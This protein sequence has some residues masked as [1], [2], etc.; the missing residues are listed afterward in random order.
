MASKSPKRIVP[1]VCA[2]LIVGTAVTLLFKT[3][4]REQADRELL[5]G[6]RSADLVAVRTALQAGANP[7]CRGLGAQIHD[8]G[9]GA[10]P[11]IR[12]LHSLMTDPTDRQP[13]MDPER[14]PSALDLAERSGNPEIVRLLLD[15][16]ADPNIRQRDGK[17]TLMVAA[18]RG[19]ADIVNVLL[20]HHADINAST[21][22]GWTAMTFALGGWR[23][24][25][26][27]L[28]LHRG[29]RFID[30]KGNPQTAMVALLNTQ[31]RANDSAVGL[32]TTMLETLL[33]AGVPANGRNSRGEPMVVMAAEQS[34]TSSIK[35]NLERLLAHGADVNAPAPDGATALMLATN[36]GSYGT[37]KLLLDHGA[38]VNRRTSSGSTALIMA[39][40][41][42]TPTARPTPVGVR[43]RSAPTVP[44][45]AIKIAQILLDHGAEVNAESKLGE[46]PLTSAIRAGSLSIVNLLL[47]HGAQVNTSH[48][49]ADLTVMD[50][51]PTPQNRTPLMRS[52]TPLMLAAIYS[53]PH[54]LEIARLLVRNGARVDAVDASGNTAGKLALLN[55][56]WKL[57]R[58][59]Q[60]NSNTTPKGRTR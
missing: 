50:E 59:L 12:L 1:L 13:S 25:V 53:N 23:F 48:F 18:A 56:N 57:A 34:G 49:R 51:I 22:D 5:E 11:L 16:G 46:T 31:Q 14:L 37:V 19:E 58:L 54:S 55:R 8:P 21:R 6:I 29:A 47:A 3:L 26:V 7:N 43:P 15:H 24:E 45:P 9:A 36:I 2:L 20:D 30:G 39:A 60:T 35:A 40:S 32:A 38:D 41:L 28:L 52:E 33:N 27:R 44:S 42:A 10:K 4:H 17:T